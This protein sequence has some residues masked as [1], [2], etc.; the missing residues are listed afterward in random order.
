MLCLRNVKF[1]DCTLNGF[2]FMKAVFE[3]F[4]NPFF[5]VTKGTAF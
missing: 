5:Y 1:H 4:D 2:N 3:L